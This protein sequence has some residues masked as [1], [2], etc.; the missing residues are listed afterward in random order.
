M[1]ADR[2]RPMTAHHALITLLITLLAGMPLAGCGVDDAPGDTTPQVAP[3]K[4]SPTPGAAPGVPGGGG[5]GPGETPPSSEVTTK[6]DCSVTKCLHVTPTGSGNGSGSDWANAFAGLP[7]SLVRGATYF[8]ATGSYAGHGFDDT[9]SGDLTILVKKASAADHGL[10][11]GWSPALG[12]GQAVFT[13]LVFSK[14]YYV[15]DGVTGGGPGSWASGHGFKVARTIASNSSE[16]VTLEADVSNITLKHTEITALDRSDANKQAGVKGVFGNRNL[17]FSYNNIHT[18][19]GVHF[20][21]GNWQD[22]V[23]EY[24]RMAM[25]R[26]TPEWHS[27]G[28]SSLGTNNNVT[29]RHNVWDQVEGT[30]VIAGVNT[31][32]S[33]AWKVYGNI[34]SRSVSPIVYY[35][36]AGSTNH[37]FMNDLEFYNNIVTGIQA[38]QGGVMIQSGSRNKAYNNIFFDNDVNAL[39]ISADKKSNYFSKNIRTQSCNP[40]C[41]RDSQGAA[42]D[43]TAQITSVNPFVNWNIGM[44]PVAADFRLVAPTNAGVVLPAPFN[45]DVRGVLRGADGVWDRGVFFFGGSL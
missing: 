26:S 19:F 7:E 31:G 16:L 20:H 3:A 33:N 36:E 39:E 15:F 38:S 32:S 9:N 21:I 18:L 41:E 22:V 40:A 8:V 23:I 25:N 42:G 13:N 17:V 10:D 14:S 37:N 29:I 5:S 45:V 30:G 35:D 27:E 28:I 24:S 6:V 4:Q 12:D 1:N 34:I 43:P 11:A 2:N 44:D